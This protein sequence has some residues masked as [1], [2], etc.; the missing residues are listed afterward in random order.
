MRHDS[1]LR[2]TLPSPV[3]S[4]KPPY[5][6]PESQSNTQP[7]CSTDRGQ[8]SANG[9][10][11]CRVGSLSNRDRTRRGLSNSIPKPLV[12][13][14]VFCGSQGHP[15]SHCLLNAF[16]HTSGLCSHDTCSK[17][18]PLSHSMLNHPIRKLRA[19]FSE[20]FLLNGKG[21]FN[22]TSSKRRGGGREK[23]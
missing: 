23:S 21:D 7:L 3:C 10:P 19:S 5:I 1:E 13:K 2:L 6:W 4:T 17:S 12:Q 11:Q 20:A 8:R 18:H 22:P 16:Q 9:F 14:A 15:E